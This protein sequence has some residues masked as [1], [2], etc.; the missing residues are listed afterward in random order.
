MQSLIQLSE[1]LGER[2]LQQGEVL[3]TAESCT[4]GGVANMVTEVAGSSAWFDRAFVT[5]SN[6]AKQE[7]LGVA[8]KTLADFGAVSEAVV[9]EM[10]LGTLAHS[11]ATIAVSISGI[12]GPSGGSP[13][14]PVGTVCFGFADKHGWL[15]CE[16]CYFAGDRAKVRIQAIEYSLKVLCDA[17]LK[18]DSERQ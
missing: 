11:N 18:N 10:V 2:L 15:R 14:K 5:Y 17:L 13:E 9:K 16:T 4:G 8:E 1:Q 7:M 6:E 12:A 3:A